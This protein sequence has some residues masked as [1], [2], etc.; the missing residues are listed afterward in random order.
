M[1]HTFF[2][3][4]CCAAIL[5]LVSERAVAEPSVAILPVQNEGDPRFNLSEATT[6]SVWLKEKF[7]SLRGKKSP[8]VE[9]KRLAKMQELVNDCLARTLLHKGYKVI[10]GPDFPEF[11]HRLELRGREVTYAN[12]HKMIPADYFL[13]V[14]IQEWDNRRFDNEGQLI[15]RYS[16]YLI[17]PQKTGAASV[18]WKKEAKRVIELEPSAFAFNKRE[19]E[20]LREFAFQVLRDLPKAP[21]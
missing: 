15:V 13:L 12:L 4:I 8:D 18:V 7:A 21:R 2:K 1:K 19:E 11:Y 16:A 9:A 5:A 14:N 3:A 10:T 17:N 6:D 20:A